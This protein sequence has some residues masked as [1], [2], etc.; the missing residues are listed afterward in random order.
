MAKHGTG[1]LID[2]VDARFD[3]WRAQ[4]PLAPPPPRPVLHLPVPAH[5]STPTGLVQTT[6]VRSLVYLLLMDC[7]PQVISRIGG[8]YAVP[9]VERPGSWATVELAGVIGGLRCG[10]TCD[11][12]QVMARFTPDS[13]PSACRHV[14]LVLWC[15]T[16]PPVQT[17]WGAVYPP[18]AAAWYHFCVRRQQAR[19]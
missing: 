12:E 15:L 16:P 19:R 17:Q 11:E 1:P 8:V 7:V 4:A 9:V 10:C 2:E 18:L 5:P 13:L 6:M 3:Q 14:Q